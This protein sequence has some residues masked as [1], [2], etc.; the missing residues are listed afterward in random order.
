MKKV[1]SL[2]KRKR[3][4]GLFEAQKEEVRREIKEGRADIKM[5]SL[6]LLHFA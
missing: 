4:E 5:S 6:F 3:R 1:R 2:D